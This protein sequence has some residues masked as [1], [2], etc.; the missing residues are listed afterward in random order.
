MPLTAPPSHA[1]YASVVDYRPLDACASPDCRLRGDELVGWTD[2]VQ[3]YGRRG[4]YAR[5]GDPRTEL[6]FRRARLP[7]EVALTLSAQE[8]VRV[9]TDG[10]PPE[11]AAHRVALRGARFVIYADTG[12]SIVDLEGSALGSTSGQCMR[13]CPKRLRRCRS[14]AVLWIG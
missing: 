12:A 8:R 13:S 10:A 9:S 4:A 2:D 7:C 5:I 3:P 11:A 1:P 6:C 14:Y